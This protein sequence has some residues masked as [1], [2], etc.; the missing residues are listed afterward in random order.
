MALNSAMKL[1]FLKGNGDREL[2]FLG[3]LSELGFLGLGFCH[4]I[5]SANKRGQ[6]QS[7]NTCTHIKWVE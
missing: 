6:R 2:G 1:G 5:F 7:S 3:F 4:F